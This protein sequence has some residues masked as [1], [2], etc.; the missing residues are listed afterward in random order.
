MPGIDQAIIEHHLGVDPAHKPVFQK[1]RLF[2]EEKY[3]TI[4]KE[5]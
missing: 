4:D 3:A 5:V 1:W 2:S